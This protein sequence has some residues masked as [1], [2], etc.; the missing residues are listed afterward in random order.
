MIIIVIINRNIDSKGWE[1]SIPKYDFYI[2]VGGKD[3]DDDPIGGRCC[4][5]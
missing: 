4:T 2:T 5:M 1:K 3:E